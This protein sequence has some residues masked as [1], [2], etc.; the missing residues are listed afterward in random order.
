MNQS[1]MVSP[2]AASRGLCDVTL[3]VIAPCFNEEGNIDALVDRTLG[4]FD[5]LKIEGELILV[6]DGSQDH[7][8]Q[9]IETRRGLDRRVC[10]QRQHVNCGIEAACVRKAPDETSLVTNVSDVPQSGHS[11][12]GRSGTG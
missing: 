12:E 9:R 4:T 10:A 1:Q 5:E 7:T 11:G 2:P 8:W 6:D 3:S